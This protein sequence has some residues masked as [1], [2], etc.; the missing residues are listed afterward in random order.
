[1]AEPGYVL[2]SNCARRAGATRAALVVPLCMREE[3]L[4]AAIE[5]IHKGVTD[6]QIAITASL[7]LPPLP[8]RRPIPARPPLAACLPAPPAAMGG[9]PRVAVLATCNLDQWAMDF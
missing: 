6:Y 3:G 5:C 2:A 8:W 7:D 9:Q 4:L 1:M